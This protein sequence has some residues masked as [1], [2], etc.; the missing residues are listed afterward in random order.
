M[1]QG[2]KARR[3]RAMIDTEFRAGKLAGRGKIR[4]LGEGGLFVNTSSVPPQGESVQ[5]RFT[6]P[7]EGALEV[8][9][10]VWWTTGRGHKHP[11]FGVRL[12]DADD[13]Y[14]RLVRVLLRR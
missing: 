8:T 11:G 1:E 6:S 3:A 13:R 7:T 4:N 12:L 2:R 14:Q 10:L 9:G 5:V